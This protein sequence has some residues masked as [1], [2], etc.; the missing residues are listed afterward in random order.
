MKSKKVLHRN[1]AIGI[2]VGGTD[3][4]SAVVDEAG[5]ILHAS[6]QPAQSHQSSEVILRNIL[7]AFEK[8][9]KWLQARKFHLLG[10]GVGIPGIVSLQ[11]RVYRSPHF[12]AWVDYPIL[13][14]LKKKIPFPV[15]VDNDAN[16]AALGEG[17]KGA[18]RKNRNYLLLTLGTGIGGGIVINRKLFRG[19]SG[20]AGEMGHLVL[21]K[22]GYVCPCGGQGCLELYASAT[23]LQ[24]VS[25][26]EAKKLYK[27]ARQGDK[28][29]KKIFE[30]LGEN[31]GAGIASLLNIL[32]IEHILVG[33][34]LSA[35]W[36][37]FVKALHR[38]VK[39][40]CYPTLAD[41]LRVRRAQ[42][43][44]RAGVVGAARAVLEEAK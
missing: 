29:A 43:G 25:P 40:H 44:N 4:K 2:D 23:G 30:A 19:D 27:L 1:V 16:M 41:R 34:G 20:F 36:D 14:E 38:G 37:F 18:A 5:R 24:K 10:V 35:A 33:G 12:P 42:L 9:R 11:G 31:L 22:E 3:I 32:D 21:Y 26:L 15:K 7:K 39:R 13:K 6:S 17:W 8:E 28:N